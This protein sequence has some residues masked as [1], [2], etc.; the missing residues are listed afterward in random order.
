MAEVAPEKTEATENDLLGGNP[1]PETSPVTIEVADAPLEEKDI[2]ELSDSD[3]EGMIKDLQEEV[4]QA[5][6]RL[7][8][9]KD[10]CVAAQKAMQ[11]RSENLSLHDLNKQAKG[12]TRV[13]DDRRR[14]SAA[15]VRTLHLGM[16][17]RQRRD[18]TSGVP[19]LG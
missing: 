2:R 4:R 11:S 6:Y 15:A 17:R 3:L 12:N 19:T 13:E 1:T 14:K 5:T 8:V 7:S 9:A 16:K 18:G 10:D